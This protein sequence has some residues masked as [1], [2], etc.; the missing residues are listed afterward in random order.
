MQQR[1]KTE[2]E[3]SEDTFIY[4]ERFGKFTKELSRGKL[5]IKKDTFCKFTFIACV[6]FGEVKTHVC[7]T[8]LKTVLKCLTKFIILK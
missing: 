7:R 8:S 2:A 1:V 6:L 4:Y 5:R 3:S